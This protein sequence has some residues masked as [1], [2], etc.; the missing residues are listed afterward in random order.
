MDLLKILAWQM[1]GG[2]S[3]RDVFKSHVQKSFDQ[4]LKEAE[5]IEFVWTVFSTSIVDVAVRSL[6]P[7]VAVN[8]EPGG[9]RQK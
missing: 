8:P 9:E 3:V 7:T 4:N 2:T 6:V 5:N 1:F